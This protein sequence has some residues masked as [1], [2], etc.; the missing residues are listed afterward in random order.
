MLKAIVCLAA[1]AS[2]LA[3]QAVKMSLGEGQSRRQAL[4]G[5]AAFGAAIAGPASAYVLPDLP[6][7]Y[8]ANAA[9]RKRERRAIET[10]NDASYRRVARGARQGSRTVGPRAR[11]GTAAAVRA[12]FV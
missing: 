7:A 10:P 3:P 11:R 1:G 9:A 4:G 6:Y 2:A 8:D 5:L 12:H